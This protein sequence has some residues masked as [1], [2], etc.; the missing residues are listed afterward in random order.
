MGFGSSTSGALRQLAVVLALAAGIAPALAERSTPISRLSDQISAAAA[1][2]RNEEGLAAAIKLEPLVRRQQGT[3][4]IGYAGVLHNQGMFLHNLGRYREAA[5]KLEASLAIKLREGNADSAL[6]TSAI[7]TGVADDARAQRR[8]DG[9]SP[10]RALAV[11]T[12]AFGP[13]DPRL[14]RPL[15]SL[16]GLAREQENFREAEGYFAR[17]LALRQAAARPDPHALADALDDLGDLYGLQGRFDDG[18]RLLKQSLRVLEQGYGAQVKDAPNY[19]KVFND[20]GNL[21]RDAGRFA[22]AESAY[23]NALA[24]ARAKLGDAHPNVAANL[25]NL[26]SVMNQTARYV[27]SEGF[28]MRA[29]LIYEKV[30]GHDS[31]ITAIALNNLANNYLDQGRPVEAMGLLQRVL[32]IREKAP[33]PTPP[34]RRVR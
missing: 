23:G 22:E 34:T 19:A 18:E 32:A 12:Q 21:Y 6:G 10:K 3:Q 33:G 20:L 1:A 26:A 4:G 14:A 24:L 2:G 11:G 27:E 5:D 17:V 8:R 30:F 15:S 29:L 7:L 31:S 28:N 13:D 16:G 25:G 9:R